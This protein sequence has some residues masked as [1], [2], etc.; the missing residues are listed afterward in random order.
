MN[1]TNEQMIEA[2]RIAYEEAQFYSETV[3]ESHPLPITPDAL[4][5]LLRERD[6]LRDAERLARVQLEEARKERDD[7]KAKAEF[8]WKLYEAYREDY[9][10]TRGLVKLVEQ[11]RDQWREV[12]EELR[13]A[14]DDIARLP[15]A[16]GY[17]DGPCLEPE[18]MALLKS[19]RARFDAL[20]AQEAGQ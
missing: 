12:A 17:V 18:D 9:R 11:Q 4:A 10:R 20:K 1:S 15:I 3:R 13:Y 6:K 7:W 5:A 14:T 2:Q 19:A 16:K 8:R